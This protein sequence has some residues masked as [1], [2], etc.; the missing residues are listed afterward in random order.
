MHVSSVN[1]NSSR[2]SFIDYANRFMGRINNDEEKESSKIDPI[3]QTSK[4]KGIETLTT[5]TIFPKQVING[6]TIITA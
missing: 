2:N 3:E 5:Y 4:P 6:K 1:S